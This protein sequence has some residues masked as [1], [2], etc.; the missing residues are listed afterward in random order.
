M[1]TLIGFNMVCF[2]IISLIIMLTYSGDMKE[3]IIGMIIEA[4]FM[5][6]LS[7]GVWLMAG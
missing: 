6:V 7:V 3:K 4:L 5:A 1:K 2:A